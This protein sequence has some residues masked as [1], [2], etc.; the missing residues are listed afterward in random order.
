MSRTRPQPSGE[1]SPSAER[2]NRVTRL[3]TRDYKASQHRPFELRRVRAFGYGA[4]GAL[5]G[6]LLLARIQVNKG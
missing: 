4:L 3:T 1:R 2:A 5:L 6:V